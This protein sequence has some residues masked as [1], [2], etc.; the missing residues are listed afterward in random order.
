MRKVILLLFIMSGLSLMNRLQAQ[1]CTPGGLTGV[2][3]GGSGTLLPLSAT[4]S[5]TNPGCNNG[6]PV[7]S[8]TLTVIGG[9]YFG[10]STAATY[11]YSLNGGTS[12][13]MTSAAAYNAAG[14][15]YTISNVPAAVSP[16][17]TYDIWVRDNAASLTSYAPA[18]AACSYDAPNVTLTA[19]SAVSLSA[20]VTDNTCNVANGVANSVIDVTVTGGTGSFAYAWSNSAN[21]QDISNVA[22]GTYTLTVT[23]T[24]G[25]C[26]TT[27]SWSV[28]S[29]AAMVLTPT[30]TQPLCAGA[31]GTNTGTLSIAVASGGTANFAYNWTGVTGGTGTISAYNTAA[32][33]TGVAPGS[34]TVT[35]T[36]GAGLCSATTNAA[37]TAPTPISFGTPTV[38]NYNGFGVHCAVGQGTSN[39]G[40]IAITAT[41]GTGAY[42]YTV[43][44]G[45]TNTT[46]SFTGLT[47]N[48]YTVTA[49]DGNACSATSSNIAVSAPI[50]ITA[51]TCKADDPCQ[52]GAGQ[53][54][55]S[56]AGGAASG[57]AG[58]TG[59]GGYTVNMT[60]SNGGTGAPSSKSI[61]TSGTSS[62][63]FT[64]LSGGGIYNFVV[65]DAN[66]CQIP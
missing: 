57:A 40:T 47:A 41:G 50:A 1:S 21:T 45:A 24:P 25:A 60:T 61:A 23:E 15:V 17:I 8:I 42:N 55:V 27:M 52:L 54:T 58:F 28:T 64:G 49:V 30:V 3:I 10:T 65:I 34:Y 46:G 11:Q 12:W 38:S 33:T 2:T 53:I 6:T 22:N 35:V 44:G 36:H 4:T 13:S 16:G 20:S 29:P 56:A 43:S 39:D 48:T 62:A 32:N 51:S 66:G 19:P 31:Q 14:T 5:G 9:T 59:V 18:P 26:T 63:P 37:I 7:G